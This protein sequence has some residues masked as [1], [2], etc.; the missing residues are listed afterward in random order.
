MLLNGQPGTPIQRVGPILESGIVSHRGPHDEII[1][2]CNLMY[3]MFAL[4]TRVTVHCVLAL[5][6]GSGTTKSDSSL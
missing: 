1:S 4:H 2:L 5:V 6:K 3:P